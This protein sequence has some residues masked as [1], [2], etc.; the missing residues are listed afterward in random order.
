MRR[1]HGEEE[2]KEAVV[3]NLPALLFI[4]LSYW[5]FPAAAKCCAAGSR[6]GSYTFSFLAFPSPAPTSDAARL[7]HS[8]RTLCAAS[9]SREGRTTRGTPRAEA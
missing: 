1:S 9:S 2:L 4:S 3:Q 6:M 7:R 8:E 5:G